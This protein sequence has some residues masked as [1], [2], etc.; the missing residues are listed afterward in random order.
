MK[1]RILR[2]AN[3]IGGSCVE[4]E[5]AGSRIVLDVGKPLWATWGEV[6]PLPAVSG[7]ADGADPSLVGVV[8]SPSPR[9]LWI[10]RP[11]GPQCAYLHW[12]RSGRALEGR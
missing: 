10:D 11:S 4:V 6:V 2:G 9:S 7:L 12:T 3:E 8:I 1:V 5:S